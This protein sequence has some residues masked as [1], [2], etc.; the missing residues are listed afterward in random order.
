[1]H[2]F[3][4][5]TSRLIP[6][7]AAL[8]LLLAANASQ[9]QTVNLTA[10]PTS[11]TL[12]DGQ[13]VPMWGYICTG[14]D[15]TSGVTCVAANPAAGAGWSPIVITVPSGTAT[16][17][18]NLTNNLPTSVPTSLV[19]AGQLGGGLELPPSTT[20]HTTTTS[21]V[22][23]PQ[24]VTWPAAS[25]PDSSALSITLTTGGSGYT[26][27]P[28]VLFTGGGANGSGAAAVATIDAGGHVISV[29]ATSGGS[30]YTSPPTISFSGGGGSGATANISN[31][32]NFSTA[33]NPTGLPPAQMPR[34]Q[35][36]GTEVAAGK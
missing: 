22:H 3:T 11:T 5:K 13:S 35:S 20:S 9:A 31:F 33:G 27:A 32:A 4:S 10:A 17:T 36:F 34:V 24:G 12:P 30:G 21:P 25:V 19:I 18:I 15:G 16:F 1:M 8:V 29:T 26:S 7:L 6:G 2:L 28:T 14:T 23:A